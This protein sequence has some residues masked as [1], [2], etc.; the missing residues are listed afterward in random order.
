MVVSELL[1]A[2]G[3]RTGEVG[4][5]QG[6]QEGGGAQLSSEMRDEEH[7]NSESGLRRGGCWQSGSSRQA[8][9]EKKQ[10]TAR[11][12]EMGMVAGKGC[13]VSCADSNGRTGMVGK[14]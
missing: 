13:L 4:K 11:P 8:A 14:V 1:E 12:G 2:L 7:G 5:L 10:S 9:Q 6:L 3:L